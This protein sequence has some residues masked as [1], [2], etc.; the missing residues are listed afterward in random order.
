MRLIRSMRNTGEDLIL[1]VFRQVSS[2]Q[3]LKSMR[4]TLKAGLSCPFFGPP[5]RRPGWRYRKMVGG[6]LPNFLKTL[7]SWLFRHL[8]EEPSVQNLPNLSRGTREGLGSMETGEIVTIMP[9]PVQTPGPSLPGLIP[10][11]IPRRRR[12]PTRPHEPHPRPGGSPGTNVP[13]RSAAR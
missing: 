6:M 7:R 4:R 13:R 8:L 9:Q 5:S 10:G 2:Q 11:I 12:N 3:F 1:P